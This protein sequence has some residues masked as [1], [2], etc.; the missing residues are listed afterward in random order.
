MSPGFEAFLQVVGVIAGVASAWYAF[1]QY[2][3]AKASKQQKVRSAASGVHTFTCA[4]YPDADSLGM[5]IFT[6]AIGVPGVLWVVITEP[7]EGLSRILL[8]ATFGFFMCYSAFMFDRSTSPFTVE[9][10][11]R[12]FTVR[13]THRK[14]REFQIPWDKIDHFIFY[15]NYKEQRKVIAVL[16]EGHGFLAGL[17]Q[18]RYS[19]I[20]G[21]YEMC[22]LREVTPSEQALRKAITQY[23]GLEVR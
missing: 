9:L 23:S 20:H 10:S 15:S 17:P 13:Q 14:L 12:H 2:Q 21:G 8:A 3:M 16:P 4:R 19:A 6:G 1:K 18:D 22:D 7:S 5:G 11:D